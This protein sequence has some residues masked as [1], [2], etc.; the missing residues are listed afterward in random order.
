MVALSLGA[1]TDPISFAKG[2][3]FPL[4]GIRDGWKEIGVIFKRY[5]E[6]GVNEW[7]IWRSDGVVSCVRKHGV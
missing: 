5:R 6:C 4:A 7:Y 2:T 1:C 3:P